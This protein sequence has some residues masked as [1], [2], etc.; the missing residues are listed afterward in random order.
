[1]EKDYFNIGFVDDMYTFDEWKSYYEAHAEP[2]NPI[3]GASLYF[4]PAHG[5]FYYKVFPSGVLRM[6]KE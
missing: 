1:M 6:Y 4:E 2:A 3:D 5:F